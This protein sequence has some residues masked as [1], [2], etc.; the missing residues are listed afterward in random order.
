M[1]KKQWA[2]FSG[3]LVSLL[4]C[5]TLALAATVVSGSGKQI[6]GNAGR[7]AEIN[8]QLF[9]LPGAGTITNIESQGASGFWIENGDGRLII[10]FDS[11]NQ[12]KGYN[13]PAGKYRVIPNIKDGYNSCSVNVTFNCP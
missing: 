8:G 12:A 13:L 11:I 6:R 2:R 5:S 9:T 3:I 1:M 4:L 10:N 7:N